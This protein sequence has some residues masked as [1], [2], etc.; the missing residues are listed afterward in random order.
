MLFLRKKSDMS[1]TQNVYW[2]KE[3]SVLVES[4]GV[5]GFGLSIV[6]AMWI[7]SLLVFSVIPRYLVFFSS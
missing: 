1:L 2:A 4:K 3:A 6:Y 7:A 5:R